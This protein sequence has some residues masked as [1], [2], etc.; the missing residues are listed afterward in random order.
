MCE[1]MPCGWLQFSSTL[2]CCPTFLQYFGHIWHGNYQNGAEWHG[3]IEYECQ[4]HH[5]QTCFGL[6][7][8]HLGS[9]T[10]T[11]NTY[12]YVCCM[13]VVCFYFLIVE[14]KSLQ[15]QYK[16][17]NINIV[18]PTFNTKQN[19]KL[20][21]MTQYDIVYIKLYRISVLFTYAFSIIYA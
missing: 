5:K 8:Q 12:W 19:I 4:N 16:Y 21:S 1:K 14:G 20:S 2:M 7:Y 11:D 10:R 9:M 17:F 6:T 18:Y 3:Q 13:Y 15:I